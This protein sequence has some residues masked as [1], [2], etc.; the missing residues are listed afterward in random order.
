MGQG[1]QLHQWHRNGSL[2]SRHV[3]MIEN[4]TFHGRII[5]RVSVVMALPMRSWPQIG[6]TILLD[7]CNNL[8]T[9]T[10][11]PNSIEEAT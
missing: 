10:A 9:F 4:H 2:T 6:A 3:S 1:L 11:A 8:E 5:H 7:I